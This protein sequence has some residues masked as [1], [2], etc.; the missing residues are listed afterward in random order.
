MDRLSAGQ[1]AVACGELNEADVERLERER[2]IFSVPDRE[3]R[4]RVYPAFQAWPQ[5]A[6]QPLTAVLKELETAEGKDLYGFLAHRDSCLGMLT[7][8]E[9][10]VG[11]VH[12]PVSELLGADAAQLLASPAEERLRAVCSAAQVYLALLQGW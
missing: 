3:G 10:L 7:P 1:F 4:G 8:V 2:Q 11:R 6:G 5:V 12:H 9:A